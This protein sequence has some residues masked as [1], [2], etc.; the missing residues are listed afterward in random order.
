MASRQAGERRSSLGPWLDLTQ[1][2]TSCLTTAFLKNPLSVFGRVSP[3]TLLSL[4]FS[5]PLHA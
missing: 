5:D 4:L 3:V 2:K 1:N